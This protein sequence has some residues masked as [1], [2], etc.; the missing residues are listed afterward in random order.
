VVP[1][2]ALHHGDLHRSSSEQEWW[3]R[4]KIEP[5]AISAELWASNRIR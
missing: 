1:L 2:C 4:Q 3:A 5:V